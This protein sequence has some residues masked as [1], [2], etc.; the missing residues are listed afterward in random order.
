MNKYQLLLSSLERTDR[1]L[2][3]FNSRLGQTVS[4]LVFFMML[5]M[6]LV[7]LLRHGF[8]LGSI[9]LQESIGYLHALVFLTAAAYTQK[10]DAHVRV[11][12]FYQHFNA[13]QKAWVNLIGTLLFLLPMS[14]FIFI[15]SFDYVVQSWY[16]NGQWRFEQSSQPGGLPTV[17]LLKTFIWCFALLLTLQGIADT[18]RHLATL[19]QPKSPQ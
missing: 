1:L 10:Q 12:I 3:V 17:F 15:S 2:S 16:I 7:V 19:L 18:C 11:D 5:L 4:W 14:V 6:C 8:S 9:A 13:R